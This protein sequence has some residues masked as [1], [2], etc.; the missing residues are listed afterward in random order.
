MACQVLAAGSHQCSRRNS[1]LP[2]SQV[3][4]HLWAVKYFSPA[5]CRFGGTF[6]FLSLA[7]N[8]HWKGSGRSRA[9]YCWIRNAY[10]VRPPWLDEVA[11]PAAGGGD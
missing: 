3:T 10:Q 4:L 11:A 5:I 2:H 8:A 7:E 9:S 1:Q 6:L